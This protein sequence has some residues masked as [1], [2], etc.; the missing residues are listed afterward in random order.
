MIAVA[1]GGVGHFAVQ[2]AKIAGLRVIGTGSLRNRPERVGKAFE[3]GAR[4]PPPRPR[5][6]RMNH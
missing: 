1:A 5:N 2:F 6:C 3:T 4:T